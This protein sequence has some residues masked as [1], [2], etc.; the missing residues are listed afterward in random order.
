MIRN[1]AHALAGAIL[2]LVVG[3]LTAQPSVHHQMAG[4]QGARYAILGL[5]AGLALFAVASLVRAFRPKRQ[6]AGSP[7]AAPA[8]RG[9]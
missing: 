8:K 6:P 7:Y 9:R 5:I 4:S 2:I 3:W 1:L